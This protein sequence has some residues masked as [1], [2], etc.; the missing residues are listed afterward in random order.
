MGG[1]KNTLISYKIIPDNT[2]AASMDTKA[3]PTNVMWLDNAGI[4][5]QWSPAVNGT[6]QVLVSNDNVIGDAVH[7]VVNWTVLDFGV[8][9]IVDNTNTNLLI[10][11][12]QLPFRWLAIAYTHGSG[13][14]TISAQLSSKEV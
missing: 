1:R 12:N 4:T 14:G 6:L 10:N 13:V 8:S 7:P 9:I 5:F 3:A 11:M 2:V